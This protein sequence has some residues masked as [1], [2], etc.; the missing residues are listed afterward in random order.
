MNISKLIYFFYHI[1]LYCIL[2]ALLVYIRGI[3]TG[4]LLPGAFL[5][6]IGDR[7][8]VLRCVLERIKKKVFD[9]NF[10]IMSMDELKLVLITLL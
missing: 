8:Y 1:P 7:Y 10:V 5:L 9:G 3:F 4:T 2:Y 6:R